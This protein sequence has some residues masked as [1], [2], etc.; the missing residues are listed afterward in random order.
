[1][2]TSRA[3]PSQHAEHAIADI[4]LIVHEHLAARVSD[5][6]AGIGRFGGSHT[7]FGDRATQFAIANIVGIIEQY[8]E[9]TLL[10]AGAHPNKVKTWDNKI[11]AWSDKFSEDITTCSA[12]QPMRGYYEARNAI[13]HR[14]GELTDSQRK[15]AVYKRLSAAG[16]TL[17]GFNVVVDLTTLHACAFTCVKCIE[18]LDVTR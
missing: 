17:I 10:D 6:R 18:Q 3:M 1:M 7:G 11:A 9:R 14:R 16:I 12:F 8:A 15:E 13:M 4:R 2:L 5:S